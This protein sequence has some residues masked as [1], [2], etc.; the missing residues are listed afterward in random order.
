MGILVMAD[1]D[2]I[3]YRGFWTGFSSIFVLAGL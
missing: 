3:G 1:K 2:W